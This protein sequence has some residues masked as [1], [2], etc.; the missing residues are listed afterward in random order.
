MHSAARYWGGPMV[1]VLLTGMGSDGAKGLRAMRN[2][3]HH[4]IAQNRETSAVYGMPKA[5]AAIA[6]A[7][8]ILPLDQ[9]APR[10]IELFASAR[11]NREST[12]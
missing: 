1:G 5:A 3:G 4:T 2:A 6:A 10:L 7:V 11:S 12:T 9:I 8:D